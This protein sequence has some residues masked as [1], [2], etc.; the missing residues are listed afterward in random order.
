MDDEIPVPRLLDD[1]SN[2]VT[3]RDRM[4]SAVASRGLVGHLV[5]APLTICDITWWKLDEDVVKRM[6]A[7]SVPGYVVSQVKDKATAKEVW[8]TVKKLHEGR[9]L[10]ILVELATTPNSAL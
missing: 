9:T 5:S 2:W 10:L 4:L 3:Y 7:S 8:D 1:G 6:I